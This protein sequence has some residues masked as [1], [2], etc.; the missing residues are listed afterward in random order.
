MLDTIRIKKVYRYGFKIILNLRIA[1]SIT[2]TII[3]AQTNN[4]SGLMI[5]DL[6]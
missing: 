2:T 5:N 3:M 4:I 1:E 6:F